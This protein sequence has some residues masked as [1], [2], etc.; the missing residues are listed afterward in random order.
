MQWGSLNIKKSFI[1][2]FKILL[3][4]LAFWIILSM[5]HDR[6]GKDWKNFLSL[7]SGI[8]IYYLLIGVAFMSLINLLTETFKWRFLVER[9]QP[10]SLKKSCESV[11]AGWNLALFTP[12]RLGEFGGRILYLLPENRKKGA[13]CILL[14]NLSQLLVTLVFGLVASFFWIKTFIP[15]R[16]LFLWGLGII[17][18]ILVLGFIGI[19]YS[20]N[21]SHGL[22]SRI[23][24]LK[25]QIPHLLVLNSFTAREL[26][27]SVLFSLFR[28]ILF[29]HQY[30]ILLFGFMGNHD[31]I[32]SLFCMGVIFM[33]QSIIPSFILS[34]MGIRG[35]NAVFFLSFVFGKQNLIPILA[36]AFYVWLVNIILPALVG[37]FFVLKVKSSIGRP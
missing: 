1:I 21:R 35:A 13:L 3:G 15:L 2:L 14:G 26:H 16:P 8:R 9:V 22:W 4:V 37:V 7:L 5:I 19:Y 10:L 36:T 23:P 25:S 17:S 34:D 30:I 6:A 27:I 32:A 18:G 20:L 28:Y 33:V 31:Y 12:A 24:F 29:T 11:L